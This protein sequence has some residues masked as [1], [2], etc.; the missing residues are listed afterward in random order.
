MKTLLVTTLFLSFLAGCGPS[1]VRTEYIKP[2]IPEIPSDPEFYEVY[3]SVL[4]G[5][6][7]IDRIMYCVDEDSA[8]NL[9]K[10]KELLESNRNDL[11]LIL[12]G[13]KEATK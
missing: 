12:Q 10:N 4:M 3:W 6:L 9:L 8:R 7:Y 11:K 5:P 13:L 1:V 2:T